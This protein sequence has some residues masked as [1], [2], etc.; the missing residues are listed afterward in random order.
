MSLLRPDVIKQHKPTKPKINLMPCKYQSMSLYTVEF[1]CKERGM[2]IPQ[3]YNFIIA[4]YWYVG[5]VKCDNNVLADD[6]N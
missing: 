6:L 4:G 3:T 2:E 5:L 1:A